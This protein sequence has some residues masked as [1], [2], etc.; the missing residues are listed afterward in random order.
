M[1]SHQIRH[2]IVVAERVQPYPGMNVATPL[3]GARCI[4]VARLVLVPEQGQVESGSHRERCYR[5]RDITVGSATVN[6][7]AHAVAA[8][9]RSKLGAPVAI[10]AIITLPG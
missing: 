4:L 6:H 3:H 5:Q 10:G 1:A 2:G 9:K 7:V 8:D